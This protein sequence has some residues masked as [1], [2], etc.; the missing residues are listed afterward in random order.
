MLPPCPIHGMMCSRKESCYGLANKKLWSLFVYYDLYVYN[1]IS[2]CI[3][4][5]LCR[6]YDLLCTLQSVCVYYDLYLYTMISICI[7][8]SLCVQC[9]LYVYTKISMYILWSFVYTAISMCIL[10]SICLYYDLCLFVYFDL[11]SYDLITNVDRRDFAS[12]N[13]ERLTNVF[14]DKSETK[15]CYQ[16]FHRNTTTTRWRRRWW[17]IDWS[18]V[19]HNSQNNNYGG[20]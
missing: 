6:Y 12:V 15:N 16:L 20:Y 5:S 11:Y 17:L 2:M 8:R 4:R 9:N 14:V 1:A 7:L 3:L 18:K 10:R 19:L 13:V